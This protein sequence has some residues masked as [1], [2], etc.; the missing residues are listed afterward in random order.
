MIR[1][2]LPGGSG[3]GNP[4]PAALPPPAADPEPTKTAAEP[5]TSRKALV[6]ADEDLGAKDTTL[7]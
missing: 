3:G 6:G 7:G 1:F 2:V 5:V 4:A